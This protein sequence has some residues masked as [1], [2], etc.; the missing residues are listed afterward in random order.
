MEI[1][2]ASWDRSSAC[3]GDRRRHIHHREA[4][5]CVSILC[6]SRWDG[7]CLTRPQACG[8]WFMTATGWWLDGELDGNCID[9]VW[10]QDDSGS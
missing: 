3:T 9:E 1:A 6:D 5:A 8:K 10:K 4:G 2:C 7:R